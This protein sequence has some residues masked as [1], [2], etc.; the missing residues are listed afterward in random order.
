MPAACHR[1]NL[2]ELAKG[3]KIDPTLCREEETER[4]IRILSRRQKNNPCLIGEAGVGKTAVV[5]GLAYQITQNAVPPTLFGKVIYALDLPSIIA[6]A[7]YRGE[8]EERLKS[9]MQECISNK[10]IILFIDEIHTLI[11]A[12]SAE[13]AVDAANILKPALARGEIQIIGATTFS[14]YRRYIEKDPALERRLQPVMINE[15]SISKAKSI[16]MGLRQRYEE[17]HKIPISEEA[18]NAAVELS[19]KYVNDRFLPDKA[20]DLIDEASSRARI[21]AFSLSDPILLAQKE[22]DELILKK[23]RAIFEQDFEL[24]KQICNRE[25]ELEESID[26]SRQ[27]SISDMAS[28]PPLSY[29]DIAQVV[30]DWTGIPASRIKS[31]EGEGLINLENELKARIIGQDGAIELIA[32]AVRRGRIGLKQDDQPT[33]SFIFVGPTGVGKTEICLALSEILFGSRRALIRFDMSEYMEKHSISRLIG[34]PPGYVG[35]E[36][37][38]LLT[39]RVRKNPYSLI[40]FDEIEKAHPE[41]FNIMLQILDDGVVTDAQGRKISFKNALIV[42]T[43]NIGSEF[44]GDAREIGFSSVKGGKGA[45]AERKRRIQNALK[46]TF[47]PEF[48]N[49]VDEIVIFDPLTREDL[50]KICEIMLRSLRERV[51]KLGIEVFIDEKACELV[52]ER[53]LLSSKNARNLRREIR[54]IIEN[55]LSNAIIEGDFENGARVEITAENS[56][57]VIK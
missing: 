6:G 5:E 20:I 22:K 27:I 44:E 32:Q 21:R 57:I 40:L 24:A 15:P 3:G 55:P 18:I 42:M 51:K 52:V 14:E 26:K 43:S 30:T 4:V 47:S 53:A 8:F 1:K 10:N 49:R 48:L 37:G 19:A 11:G 33:G 13:G 50:V 41:I 25:L 9:V 2:N 29:D 23:E 16:L 39:Q 45:E 56:E 28:I 36:E 7:K 38:G 46:Q 35:Y 17:H 31:G 54:R 34:S 12:G